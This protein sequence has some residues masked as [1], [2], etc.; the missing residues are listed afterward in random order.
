MSS[1]SHIFFLSRSD[2]ISSLSS[3]LLRHLPLSLHCYKIIHQILN[4]IKFLSS[5][6]HTHIFA[7]MCIYLH[8]FAAC[9][10]NFKC[11]FFFCK[12]Q[13]LKM[14]ANSETDIATLCFLV[15]I[16]RSLHT[17]AIIRQIRQ[18]LQL[19]IHGDYFPFQSVNCTYME[20]IFHFK[21]S[22]AHT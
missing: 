4:P 13:T 12:L 15:F 8:I 5:S 2:I 16:G 17:A 22:T 10:K 20:I 14:A 9:F 6:F 21:V 3:V 18:K 11:F 19:H 7:Q 1:F